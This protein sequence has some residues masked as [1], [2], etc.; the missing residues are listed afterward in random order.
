MMNRLIHIKNLLRLISLEIQDLLREFFILNLIK[1]FK[2]LEKLIKL[3]FVLIMYL[4]LLVYAFKSYFVEPINLLK[5][6]LFPLTN[7]LDI[8]S[9]IDNVAFSMYQNQ[10]ASNNIESKLDSITLNLLHAMSKENKVKKPKVYLNNFT[11][12]KEIQSEKFKLNLEVINIDNK[13]FEISDDRIR[14]CLDKNQNTFYFENQGIDHETYFGICFVSHRWSGEIDF[15]DSYL[16]ITKPMNRTFLKIK[17]RVFYQNI[18]NKINANLKNRKVKNNF[19]SLSLRFSKLTNETESQLLKN[20]SNFYIKWSDILLKLKILVKI[21]KKTSFL[22]YKINLVKNF[23]FVKNQFIQSKQNLK[24]DKKLTKKYNFDFITYLINLNNEKTI[25]F[26]TNTKK[27]NLFND[28]IT[29][30]LT[31]YKYNYK[32]NLNLLYEKTT[33]FNKYIKTF[34]LNINVFNSFKYMDSINFI[35]ISLYLKYIFLD[36][37]FYLKKEIY[38]KEL[39]IN[40]KKYIKIVEDFDY[41]KIRKYVKLYSN[42]FKIYIFEYIYNLF[43]FTN[44]TNNNYKKINSLNYK[45]IKNYK[46]KKSIFIFDNKINFILPTNFIQNYQNKQLIS[47]FIFQ[48]SQFLKINGYNKYF[49][50]YNH[51]ENI[52][53]NNYFIYKNFLKDFLILD[54]KNYIQN[55][56]CNNFKLSNEFIKNIK[57]K[58][59][60]NIKKATIKINTLNLISIYSDLKNKT[61]YFNFNSYLKN[62]IAKNDVKLNNNND[63]NND[64]VLL[65]D[66]IKLIKQNQNTQKEVNFK[67]KDIEFKQKLQLS[68][69]EKEEIIK[70][71]IN[72][73]NFSLFIIHFNLVYKF[74][75]QILYSYLSYYKILISYIFYKTK[76][77]FNIYFNYSYTFF[78][79]K[80]DKIFKNIYDFFYKLENKNIIIFSKIKL[81]KNSILIK[82]LITDTIINVKDIF[83]LAFITLSVQDLNNFNKKSNILLVSPKLHFILYS[84]TLSSLFFLLKFLF[85]IIVASI[86]LYRRIIRLN[87]LSYLDQDALLLYMFYDK[88]TYRQYYYILL[89]FLGKNFLKYLQTIIYRPTLPNFLYST[90]SFSIYLFYFTLKKLVIICT[91]QL[92]F[93]KQTLFINPKS[94]DLYYYLCNDK[95]IDISK[96]NYLY[97]KIELWISNNLLIEEKEK[98]FI[99]NFLTSFF[100]IQRKKNQTLVKIF[101]ESGYHLLDHLIN[102]KYI[103]SSHFKV[104]SEIQLISL[105]LNYIKM[106]PNKYNKHRDYKKIPF[107]SFSLTSVQNILI[108]D[109]EDEDFSFIKNDLIKN[110]NTAFPFIKLSTSYKDPHNL[111]KKF[112]KRGKIK[113]LIPFSDRTNIYKKLK[114]IFNDKDEELFNENILNKAISIDNKNKRLLSL[115]F[116]II[117]QLDLIKV[118]APC[119]VWIPNI[120]KIFEDPNAKITLLKLVKVIPQFKDIVFIVSTFKPEN[121]DPIFIAPHRL[122]KCLIIKRPR[123]ILHQRKFLFKLLNLRDHLYLENVLTRHN[124]LANSRGIRDLFTLSNELIVTNH[125]LKTKFVNDDKIRFSRHRQLHIYNMPHQNINFILYQIGQV[126]IQIKLNY[127]PLIDPISIFTSVLTKDFLY[128]HYFSLCTN[129]T[130]TNL[131]FYIFK[132]S[133]GL[134]NK[135]IWNLLEKNELLLMSNSWSNFHD[136]NL[137]YAFLEIEKTILLDLTTKSNI[138]Q[139]SKDWFDIFEKKAQ[140]EKFLY[141]D[142]EYEKYK[143]NLRQIDTF[144]RFEPMEEYFKYKYQY[145][146]IL[147]ENLLINNICE[148]LYKKKK[149]TSNSKKV[150]YLQKANFS[151]IYE[152]LQYLFIL[153]Q[154][155]RHIFEILMKELNEKKWL[156]PNELKSIFSDITI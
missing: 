8:I 27:V 153:M 81:I 119:T 68:K 74:I 41:F 125:Y 34:K 43:F 48:N 59:K 70:K 93:Y 106:N 103:Y 87:D 128:K 78:S 69:E 124:K 71:E 127:T 4:I 148:N 39:V 11:I 137:F 82:N 114:V 154:K 121:I 7:K 32:K 21:E 56:L 112:S 90:L 135:K 84:I 33:K 49:F 129:I 92:L 53:A 110:H 65:I 142:N 1:V 75:T 61:I 150:W 18:K 86:K 16:Y 91:N 85:L 95:D 104:R 76:N 19:S 117:F 62:E 98:E 77:K 29:V 63:N 38:K 89:K 35:H 17:F 149:L 155:N 14:I 101:D 58:N 83:K 24:L 67:D 108:I 25:C 13:I 99:L 134:I 22:N 118:L 45:K 94:K 131:C 115:I 60:L 23:I 136:F 140:I 47:S 15:L 51:K 3:I 37:F 147:Y 146:P 133:A 40:L 130:Q 54:T 141:E 31:L 107:T 12:P 105:A 138:T 151:F 6:S 143:E 55:I 10:K 100:P 28:I 156:F 96:K 122:S 66:Y 57:K 123:T 44:N 46:K 111:L 102:R 20:M 30:I 72:Y 88:R 132:C 144:Y 50:Y 5:Y 113:T 52:F 120:H 42:K 80:I 97:N 116:N 9:T 152:T 26:S 139:S 145:F 79:I 109:T 36:I 64:D 126:F 2:I 73:E